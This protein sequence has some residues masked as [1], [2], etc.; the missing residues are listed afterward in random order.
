MIQ[1]TQTDNWNYYGEYIKRWYPDL[2]DLIRLAGITADSKLRKLSYDEAAY[3]EDKQD[4]LS[5]AFGDPFLDHIR[6]EINEA[7]AA[8]LYLA[9]MFLSR[10]I[11]EAATIRLFEVVFPKFVNREYSPSNHDLWYDRGRNRY[12]SFDTL[13]DNLK[14]HAKAFHE[15]QRLI[16]EAVAHIQPFKNETN[17]C[18][19]ADYKIPD[20]AYL[21]AWKIPYVVGL[22]RKLFRKYCNP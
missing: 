3:T 5:H 14:D 6:K 12:H 4:F 13:L 16:L 11:L 17:L 7:Y 20:T 10:K 1:A 8:E 18:V 22:A 2:L 15:D 9:V 21:R 19:H